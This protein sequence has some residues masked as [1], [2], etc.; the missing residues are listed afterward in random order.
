MIHQASRD[1]V[2]T[3][4]AAARDAMAES[5]DSAIRA[6]GHAVP[7]SPERVLV[8]R[9]LLARADA[10]GVDVESPRGQRWLRECARIIL[11]PSEARADA[12][13]YDG[14]LRTPYSGS[15]L[16]TPTQD[17]ADILSGIP[18]R[19]VAAVVQVEEFSE[20]EIHKFQQG[21][22]TAALNGKP[23]ETRFVNVWNP[24]LSSDGTKLAAEVRLNLY[25][26]TI[27]VDGKA[28]NRTYA[29]VWGPVF[30][31]NSGS[32]LAPVRIDG[33]WAMAEDEYI[34][35][36]QRFVQLWRQMFSPDGKKLAAIVA[37]KFG[38]W[39]MAVDG[40]PWSVTF[41]DMVTDA[42][43][44]PDSKKVAA[45]AKES[46]QWKIVVDGEVWKNTFDMAWKPVFSPDGKTVVAKVEK[47]GKYTFA[48]N[49]RLWSRDC[50]AVWD[51]VFSPDGEKILLRS[52]EEGKYYRRILPVAELRK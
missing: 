44:S 15:I 29:C 5:M 37:P 49:D 20:G 21:T 33:A 25:D 40:T 41:N 4:N 51:P 18:V 28:W 3:V 24:A 48:T 1:L 39:T 26:Y 12:A 47:K 2:A 11:R 8:K 50:E 43:F 45:L 13:Y 27:A 35:W 9:H 14:T 6:D 30:N 52:V 42:V 36:K 17:R 38:K 23:W 19:Q 7:M 31:P 34:I 16:M 10:L 46:D 22:F 32:V